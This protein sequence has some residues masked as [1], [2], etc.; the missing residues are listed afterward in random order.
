MAATEMQK[1]PLT[2]QPDDLMVSM[3]EVLLRQSKALESQVER[4][5]PKE[6]PNYQVSSLFLKPS[7]E[8]FAAD[9]K[10]AIYVGPSLLNKTPLTEE[11]VRQAN[12]LRPIAKAKVLKM[13]RTT[14]I[15]SVVAKMDASDN[16]ERLTVHLPLSQDANPQMYP[17]LDELLKQLADQ[18]QA[19][20][21]A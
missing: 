11:E 6:N 14:A 7:G 17:P 18:A 15:A 4:T 9:L 2:E 16:L 8:P 13:D 10:C 5:A 3:V 1:T 19:E 21:E 20:A 12:R